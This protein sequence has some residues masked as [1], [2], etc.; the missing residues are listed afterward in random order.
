MG[1][2]NSI[3]QMY[4][5]CKT[6]VNNVK[7]IF[8]Y[9]VY[10]PVIILSLKHTHSLSVYPV[11][12]MQANEIETMLEKILILTSKQTIAI[13]TVNKWQSIAAV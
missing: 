3:K 2:Q 13:L 10:I 5:N 11:A 8:M 7:V 6:L 12:P 1:K 4:Y 9:P